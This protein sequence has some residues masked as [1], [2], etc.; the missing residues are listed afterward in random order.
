MPAVGRGIVDQRQHEVNC[1]VESTRAF[2][3][4]ILAASCCCDCLQLTVSLC[5]SSGAGNKI[6]ATLTRVS[7]ELIWQG[8]PLHPT[9]LL[10]ATLKPTLFCCHQSYRKNGTSAMAGAQFCIALS[11]HGAMRWLADAL[12]LRDRRHGCASKLLSV[13]TGSAAATAAPQ[14]RNVTTSPVAP[15]R[16][17][18]PSSAS[19][20]S[21]RRTCASVLLC[22]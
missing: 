17:R 13:L 6:S 4:P 14:Y 2:H 12:F 21:D 18:R 16:Y 3:S 20:S 9:A 1:W 11:S 19:T 5:M 10:Q 7:V 8:I 22:A 15:V